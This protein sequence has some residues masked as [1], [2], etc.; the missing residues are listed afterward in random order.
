MFHGS[1]DGIFRLFMP[2]DLSDASGGH[3]YAATSSHDDTAGHR[4]Y[5]RHSH[6]DHDHNHAPQ[7]V[8]DLTVKVDIEGGGV[9]I[10]KG[11]AGAD[12][13]SGGSGYAEGGSDGDGD[14]NELHEGTDKGGGGSAGEDDLISESGVLIPRSMKVRLDA[15]SSKVR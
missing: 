5:G 15:H 10:L 2:Y 6:R 13:G 3:D 1:N 4:G 14:G 9:T 11:D 7:T 8:P 12:G